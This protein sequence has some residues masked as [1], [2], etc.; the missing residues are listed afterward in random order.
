MESEEY[1]EGFNAYL[2]LKGFDHCQY[3]IEDGSDYDFYMD[4]HRGWWD[5]R[6]KHPEILENAIKN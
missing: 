3:D 5:A 2:N 1:L 4:W 6:K